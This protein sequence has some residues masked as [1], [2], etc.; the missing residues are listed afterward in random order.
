M[1]ALPQRPTTRRPLL[2][3]LGH[4]AA[5]HPWR[6]LGAWAVLVLAVVGL[7]ATVGGTPQDDYNV[8]GARSQV[9]IDRLRAHLPGAGNTA[10]RVVVHDRT[11]GRPTD[12]ALTDLATRLQAMPHVVQVFPAQRSADGDT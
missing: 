3:R 6:T 12:A 10:A 7:A 8:P 9:G 5:A 4:G 1:P 11:G 2:Y